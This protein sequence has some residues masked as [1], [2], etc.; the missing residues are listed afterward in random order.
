M[1]QLEHML[2]L[3]RLDEDEIDTKCEALRQN[4]AK[5]GHGPSASGKGLKKHQVHEMAAAKIEE[6]DRLRRALGISKDYEEGSHW[7]KQEERLRGSLQSGE[8][9]DRAEPMPKERDH[10]ADRDT[11]REERPRRRSFRDEDEDREERPRR[12]ESRDED[13]YERPRRRDYSDDEDSDRA[14]RRRRRPSREED[15]DRYERPRKRDHRRYSPSRSR[16]RSRSP[17]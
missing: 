9:G 4:L 11:H 6:S 1:T 14:E 5:E 15:E 7:K 16:S 3:H 17:R 10:K 12:R 2:T 8:D 13:R